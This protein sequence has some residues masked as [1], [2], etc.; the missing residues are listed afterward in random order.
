[1]TRAHADSRGEK[2]AARPHSAS[3]DD[4][5]IRRSTISPYSYSPSAKRHTRF[6]YGDYTCLL[7]S[8]S[9]LKKDGT[10]DVD[11][12]YS[13]YLMMKSGLE[14]A[15]K[16]YYFIVRRQSELY[17][18]ETEKAF[19]LWMAS[20][21]MLV[22]YSKEA[23][24][25]VKRLNPVAMGTILRADK[26]FEKREEDKFLSIVLGSASKCI[27]LQFAA[28]NEETAT[29]W[30]DALQE[31][32][33]TKQHISEHPSRV[34]SAFD[35]KLLLSLDEHVAL[36]RA[37]SLTT[38]AES[39]KD[40]GD[41]A[42]EIVA[43]EANLTIDEVSDSRESVATD[44]VSSSD[45]KTFYVH[46]DKRQSKLYTEEA[47]AVLTP[48]FYTRASPTSSSATFDDLDRLATLRERAGS[49]NSNQSTYA[50]RIRRMDSV[51]SN[52]STTS[53]QS[54]CSTTGNVLLFVPVV[55]SSLTA[56][57]TKLA[58]AKR[59]LDALVANGARKPS[60]L[61]QDIVNGET[62]EW[63]YGFPEY[64]LTDLVYARGCIRDSDT[65]SLTSYVE[66]CCQT[67]VM[68][69]THKSRYDQWQSVDRTRF[70][71]QVND[72]MQI[73]GSSIFENDMFGLLYFGDAVA[74]IAVNEVFDEHQDPRAM[75]PEAFPDGFPLEVLDVFTQPPQCY[76]SWRHWGPFTGM[77]KGI[78]GD[79]GMVEVRGFGEM[80]LDSSRMQSLRLFYNLKDLISSLQ[81]AIDR[82][83]R[84]RRDTAT[85]DVDVGSGRR[86]RA[87]SASIA[88]LRRKESAPNPKTSEIIEGLANFTIE[89][90]KLRRKQ[91][92]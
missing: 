35:K 55:G 4:Y 89:A 66:E 50:T 39:T 1:M 77:C 80:T 54:Q 47:T 79:G 32:Q 13:G 16:C 46:S 58:K 26:L 8:T 83:V 92:T 25:G 63:R 70:Y 72:G 5:A 86:M 24:E 49:T 62:I 71:M 75:L 45:A 69:A 36:R 34:G 43:R 30:L 31:V 84:T 28:E 87:T 40:D 12:G 3:E 64:V 57:A 2:V 52:S 82:V 9:N 67:F 81:Q 60:R 51:A 90:N 48:T 14:V 65:S 19:K 53:G 68:E 18:C 88:S 7:P 91:T 6:R 85:I 10:V 17:M 29:Q 23:L 74:Y 11:V 21:H 41:T 15:D 27:T 59:E 56:S 33:V 44:F 73:L 37:S 42:G 61:M 76:F 38:L 78:K 20:N 22:G